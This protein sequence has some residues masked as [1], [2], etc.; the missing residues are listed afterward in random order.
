MPTWIEGSMAI[1]ILAA[2]IAIGRLIQRVNN[3]EKNIGK[4]DERIEGHVKAPDT[5]RSHGWEGEVRTRLEDMKSTAT[6][7]K[8]SVEALRTKSDEDR[9]WLNK[10]FMEIRV[11]MARFGSK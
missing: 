3:N 1:T 9:A 7:I 11:D 2:F 4:L 8:E 10:S 6:E 5:H